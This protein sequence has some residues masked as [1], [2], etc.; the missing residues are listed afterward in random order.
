M[1]HILAVVEKQTHSKHA[2]THREHHHTQNILMDS[3]ITGGRTYNN[4]R[5]QRLV[6]TT[7]LIAVGVVFFTF[8]FWS[9]SSG[10]VLPPAIIAERHSVSDVLLAAAT[11]DSGPAVGDAANSATGVLFSGQPFRL[12]SGERRFSEGW[13]KMTNKTTNNDDDDDDMGDMKLA[14]TNEHCNRWAVVTTISGPTDAVKVAAEL[15]GKRLLEWK[16][17]RFALMFCTIVLLL[18]SCLPTS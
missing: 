17:V 12:F 3:F 2:S 4:K 15:P 7:V 8:S 9:S 16:A 11:A 6:A 10:A 14:T 5:G 1:H 18:L 13:E